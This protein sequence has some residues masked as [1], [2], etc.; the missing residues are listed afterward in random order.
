MCVATLEIIIYNRRRSP[1]Q[2]WQ[3][4]LF[5]FQTKTIAITLGNGILAT[6]SE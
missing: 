1:Q 3:K 2:T 6:G 4:C 5:V